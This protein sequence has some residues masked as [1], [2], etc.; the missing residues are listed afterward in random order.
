M[1]DILKHL[2]EFDIEY[3]EYCPLSNHTTFKV[4]G[5]ARVIA[6]PNSLKKLR[7]I[8]FL[9]D[10]RGVKFFVLG[11][12]SNIV[13]SDNGYN[14][15][16]IKLTKMCS[17]ITLSGDNI[18]CDSA[19][20]LNKLSLFARDN[21]LSGAQFCYGIPATLGGAIFMNAGAYGGEMRDIV[22]S[23][24][25]LR[26][27]GE[28]EEIANSK[29]NFGYRTSV[30]KKTNDIILSAKLSLIKGNYSEIN[31]E[32]HE[33]I[34]KR[35][36]KQPLNYPSAG[37]TFKRP[38]DNFAAKLIEDAG[39]KGY[40]IGGAMVSDKHSG[41]IINYD[42]ATA[43]DILKLIEYIKNDVYDKFGVQLK[44]E[45]IVVEE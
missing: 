3:D 21:N 32:M 25:V 26:Q 35:R 29:C 45:V 34:E 33:I 12:G 38:P 1:D 40:R 6:Y 5:R 20:L 11:A 36:D 8:L 4:G 16:I 17:D 23:V 15:I 9:A 19:V 28:V 13:F 27:N 30:F 18:I 14:G 39:L 22:S 2:K 43:S 44:P 41:F 24:T 10:F 31:K 7:E 42:K 37:S